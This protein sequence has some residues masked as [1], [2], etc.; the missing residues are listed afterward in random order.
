MAY[1]YGKRP[2]MLL[3]NTSRLDPLI[4]DLF[5]ICTPH[6]FE[7]FIANI[8]KRQIGDKHPIEEIEGNL[9]VRVGQS[10]ET[11]FSCHMDMIGQ[12]G[13]HNEEQGRCDSI[14]LVTPDPN[15]L[16]KTTRNLQGMLYAC[17]RI[18]NIETRELLKYE[19]CTIGADDKVGVYILLKMIEKNINGLYVFHIGEECGGI[20]SKLLSEKHKDQFKGIKRAIAFDRAGYSDI[21]EH[22]RGGRCCSTIFG[23]ALAKS[24]NDTGNIP[25]FSLFKAGVHGT[26]TDTANYTSI[27]PECTNVSVGYFS[28]HGSDEHFDPVWLHSMLLPAILAVDFNLLPTER[29]PK[30]VASSYT[31]NYGT[32]YVSYVNENRK[33]WK[34]AD[35]DT[36]DWD[37]PLWNP[38][39]GFID[40]AKDDVLQRSIVRFITQCTMAKEK[41]EL[42]EFVYDTLEMNEHYDIELASKNDQIKRLKALLK[43]DIVEDIDIAKKKKFLRGLTEFGIKFKYLNGDNIIKSMAKTGSK[44]LQE[45]DTNYLPE[46]FTEKEMTKLNRRIY[47]LAYFISIGGLDEGSDTKP[48]LDEIYNYIRNHQTEAGFEIR[49]QKKEL[50]VLPK[51]DTI[52]TG[53]STAVH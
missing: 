45:I 12:V 17:K 22:Q 26:F 38:H 51:N 16:I 21:I 11:M 24:L 9:L 10:N 7:H 27:I 40:F 42:A 1:S 41:E 49:Q 18:I 20:G 39:L 13:K 33:S 34:D 31:N 15:K 5:T 50:M 28:Q 32:R 44:F 2:D 29:D 30:V 36:K 25:Q 8:V 52:D 48:L 37:L 6:N 35:K 53:L 46:H 47:N 14:S 19:P 4:V 23:T 3:V 43:S